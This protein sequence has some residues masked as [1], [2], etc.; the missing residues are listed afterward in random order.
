SMRRPCGTLFPY[1]TLFRSY[2]TSR[3]NLHNGI[4]VSSI[5]AGNEIHKGNE[6]DLEEELD[7]EDEED[8]RISVISNMSA[9]RLSRMYDNRSSIDRKSTRLNSSH[10]KISYA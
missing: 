2:S 10:V 8:V 4:Q 6:E 7:D 1:T 5:S 3:G 9:N